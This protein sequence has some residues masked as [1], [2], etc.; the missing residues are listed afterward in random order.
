MIFNQIRDTLFISI[1]Q[2]AVRFLANRTFRHLHELSLRFHLERR[3]GGL[4]RI[5][6]R[7]TRSIELIIRMAVLNSIPTFIELLLICGILLWLFGWEYAL[8]VLL[9]VAAYIWYTFAASEWRMRIRRQ[10]NDA[11]TE[12]NSKTV[13]GLLNYE[14]VKYFGNEAHEL[15]R[16]D[17]SMRDYERAAIRTFYSLGILNS[18]Q[19]F[20]FT[21]GLTTC[22]LMAANG[23]AEKELTLGDF[24]M[25]NAMLLQLYLPLN[26]MGMVYREIKQGLVDLE[27]MFT[28]LYQKPEITDAPAAADLAIKD[29]VVRFNDVSFA[30]DR[31]RPILH[32]IDFE[33][34]SGKTV[35]IV[36]SSGAGKSTISR[37]M[38]RFYDVCSGSI[39]IDGQDI[40]TLTQSSLRA[41]IGMVP[42]DTVLFNDTIAYNIGYG[43]VAASADDIRKSARMA[44]IDTFIESQPDGYEAVVGERGLKLS[45]GEKQRIAIART[46]L[47]SPPIL[48]LD[49]ATSAL[50]SHTEKE[51]QIALDEVSQNRTTLIIAH[52]LSTIIHAD[53]I[54]VMEAGR[55]VER[56]THE[57]LI[58]EGATYAGMWARQQEAASR[59]A[60][61]Q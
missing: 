15:K 22:M 12:A 1:G 42:Q 16:F 4:S 14:T 44:H 11:D 49:E 43:R 56:G 61:G 38:F 54:I 59:E 20:I 47:K 31:A 5:I 36:G 25:V 6:E 9:M 55:I 60:S 35:A 8:V 32:N 41:A 40:R 48:I 33:V 18:G 3:T 39:T 21:T 46:I 50:D 29:A 13:D 19:A 2:N 17:Q 26:F 57:Q 45:G 51:I 52:R 23:V 53:Q 28:L 24:V 58:R 30:Y 34:P 7:A 27:N 10:M 37:L